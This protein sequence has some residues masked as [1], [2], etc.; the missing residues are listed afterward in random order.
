MLSWSPLRASTPRQADLLVLGA[1]ISGR[2]ERL[3]D[4]ASRASSTRNGNASPL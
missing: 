2:V 3:A 1:R 4:L